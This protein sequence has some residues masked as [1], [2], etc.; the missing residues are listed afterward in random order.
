VVTANKALVSRDRGE[1]TLGVDV[2]NVAR[3]AIS[4]RI[5]QREIGPHSNRVPVMSHIGHSFQPPSQYQLRR[6]PYQ[7]SQ[8]L[9]YNRGSCSTNVFITS[10]RQQLLRH[11]PRLRVRFLF[12]AL[13]DE[14][15]S[16]LGH[17]IIL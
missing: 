1:E 9:Q 12:M 14:F 3:M 5:V 17:R 10:T 11:H 13:W 15:Y 7:P 2:S 4:V 8:Q 6:Q 16:I